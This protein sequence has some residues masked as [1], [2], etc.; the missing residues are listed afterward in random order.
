LSKQI[1]V[2]DFIAAHFLSRFLFSLITT[3][4]IK[5]FKSYINFSEVSIY[6]LAS[7]GNLKKASK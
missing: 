4:F 5:K 1:D 2:V 7:E 6:I 3:S